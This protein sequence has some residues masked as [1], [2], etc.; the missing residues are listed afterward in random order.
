LCR[1]CDESNTHIFLDRSISQEVWIVIERHLGN[2]HLW[3]KGTVSDCFCEY[4]SR[5]TLKEFWVLPILV[6]WG[7]WLARYASIFWNKCHPSFKISQQALVIISSYKV[8]Q[9]HNHPSLVVEVEIDKS[10]AWGFFYGACQEP[11]KTCGLGLILHYSDSH[12]VQGKANMGQGTN[13]LDEFNAFLAL[14]KM[15]M[16]KDVLA[17]Q[18]FR[19]SKLVIDWMKEKS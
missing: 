8:D 17:L 16:Y 14:F 19:D 10:I 4:Y 11:D 5:P 9:V 1:R 12:F 7:V 6:V 2:N 18:V 13:N 15:S 3:D